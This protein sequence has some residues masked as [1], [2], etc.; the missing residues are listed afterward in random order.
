MISGVLTQILD[1]KDKNAHFSIAL[2]VI[3]ILITFI[4]GV[5]FIFHTDSF[6]CEACN[7]ETPHIVEICIRLI[8]LLPPTY[9]LILGIVGILRSKLKVA[10]L[11]GVFMNIC[12]L[13]FWFF[14]Y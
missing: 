1:K 4:I 12:I 14:G 8:I 11:T 7:T 13:L 6:F 3:S 5:F 10:S 2:A 9:G